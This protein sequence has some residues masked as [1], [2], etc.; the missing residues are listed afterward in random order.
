MNAKQRPDFLRLVPPDA[1]ETDD[2]AL[3]ADARRAFPDG[4]AARWLHAI[5]KLSQAGYGQGV[6]ASYTRHSVSI[7]RLLGPEPAIELAD[8]VSTLAVKSGRK[9]A[10]FLPWAALQAAERL[11]DEYRLRSWLDVMKRFAVLAPESVVPVLERIERLLGTLNVPRFEA[12]VLAGVRS[13]GGDAERRLRFFNFDDPD[14]ERWLQREAGEVIFADIE[15]RLKAY[16]IALWRLRA[17]IREPAPGASHQARRRA[18][19]DRGLIRLP[20]AFHGYRGQQAQEI[21]RASLA[22]VAAHFMYSG[23]K[24]PVRS[25][26]PVQVALIS[27]IEDA[28]VEHLAPCAEQG[29][30]GGAGQGAADAD[31][32]R[33]GVGE[34]GDGHAA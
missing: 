7:A 13:G 34:L 15:R 26:K 21:F 27:L 16:L 17:P 14:A 24:F 25:L 2:G 28:R 9:A 20:P 19:F 32:C 23:P 18:S 33:T 1:E 29:R 31:A 4:A 6:V 8:V 11:K 5:R 10:E 22:H 30:D 3:T 12:W